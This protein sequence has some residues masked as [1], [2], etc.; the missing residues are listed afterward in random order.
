MTVFLVHFESPWNGT[1]GT[2][3]IFSTR[4]KAEKYVEEQKKVLPEWEYQYV[5]EMI[6]E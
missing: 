3:K 1:S 4:E 2:S 5:C 6:V